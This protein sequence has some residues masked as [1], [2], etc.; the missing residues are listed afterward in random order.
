MDDQ[1]NMGQSMQ[2]MDNTQP[3]QDA[4]MTPPAAPV[5]D[6]SAPAAPAPLQDSGMG[7][8][9]AAP[10]TPADSGMPAAPMGDAPAAPATPADSGMPAAPMGD[11]PAAPTGQDSMPP[12]DANPPSAAPMQ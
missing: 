11:A 12:T 3:A 4:G 8:D 9:L 5:N 6:M 7:A 2:P 10:A 1:N